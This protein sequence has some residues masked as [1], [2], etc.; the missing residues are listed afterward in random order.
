MWRASCASRGA[1]HRAHV[2]DSTAQGRVMR[3]FRFAVLTI[4]FVSASFARGDGADLSKE[5]FEIM[6]LVEEKKYAEAIRGYE[7]FLGSSP[8]AMRG[9]IQF[10][11]ASLHAANGN[12][13]VALAKMEEAIRAGFDDCLAVEKYDELKLLKADPQFKTLHAKIRISEADLKELYWLKAEIEHVNHDTKMMI[14]E[15]MNRADTNITAIPQSQIPVRPTS[16]TGVLFNRQLLRMMHH[17]QRYYVMESDK[18]RM[19]HVGTMGV[20]SGGTSAEKMLESS[21]LANHAAEER[22]RAIHQRKFS[23][24]PSVGSS[25]RSCAEWK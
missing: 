1:I 22:Q 13:G 25:P 23:L 19:E 16:S 11:I 5:L 14:T 20:I 7:K 18:A 12:K 10:E 9:A 24:P 3:V 21:R 4:I 17:V 2:A 8:A 6:K 15:N